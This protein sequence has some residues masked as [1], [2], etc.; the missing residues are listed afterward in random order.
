MPTLGIA[1][2]FGDNCLGRW[3]LRAVRMVLLNE[4]LRRWRSWLALALLVALVSG[5]A[6]AATTAGRRTASAF[7][8]FVQQYGFDTLT[9]AFHPTP[10]LARLPEVE[11]SSEITFA[12][13]GTPTCQ[14]AP[15]NP[16]YF[17]VAVGLPVGGPGVKLISGR[18]P[19]P[20]ST[21]EVLASFNLAQEGI[22]IGSVIHVRFDSSSQESAVFNDS[23][24]V[25]PTGPKLTFRVV[26]FEASEFE[27]PSIGTP[28]EDLYTTSAF[29][30]RYSSSLVHFYLYFTRL[31]RGALDQG[32]FQAAASK[33]DVGGFS[34]ESVAASEVASSIHPQAVGWWVL[35]ILAGAA[36]LLTIAQAF[37]RQTRVASETF[38][39]LSAVGLGS[40]ELALLNVGRALFV[41][42][43]GAA[44]GVLL[45]IVLSPLAPVGEARI[46]D[47]TGGIYFDPFVLWLGVLITVTATVLVALWPAI[48]SSRLRTAR[49]SLPG[50][51]S[52]VVAGLSAAGAP[53]TAV[54]G[55]RRVLERGQGR[56]AV[57]VGTALVAT[58]LAVLALAA[59]AVFGTSL[60]HLTSTPALYGQPFDV[61]FDGLPQQQPLVMGRLLSQLRADRGIRDITLGASQELQI[62]HQEVDAIA[63]ISVRGPVL[64]TV[65]SGRAPRAPNE[66]ALGSTT[67]RQVGAQVGG[68]VELTV[69]GISGG[70]HTERF[71]VVGTVSIPIDFGIGGLGNGAVLT[72]PGLATAQCPTGPRAAACVASAE[73]SDEQAILVTGSHR[74]IAHFERADP[75]LTSIPYPPN[76]LVNFGEAVDFPLIIGLVLLLFGAATLL[77]TLVVSATRRRSETG[78][79]KALGFVRSQLVM[80]VAWQATTIALV[81]IVIGVPLGV[82]VGNAVWHLFANNLG[83]FPDTVVL[84]SEMA[85]V[86][87]GVL[88][89][90]NLLAIAPAIISSR[91]SPAQ[92]LRAQ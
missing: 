43:G 31:K 38:P 34:D 83:L 65:V 2:A 28:S 8:R 74:A 36:G 10:Q 49:P 88:L 85:A 54:V 40:S 14:C 35:A 24:A 22:H 75:E 70:T 67:L 77:H 25:K 16:S 81:G 76:N 50:R 90:A 57:P 62:N 32:A 59:T 1:E 48:R 4:A 72:V 51:P 58:V 33:F 27:F 45:A 15:I 89:V 21:T 79:L 69:P 7:P 26:G 41:A 47:P 44:G 52:A 12:G 71:R 3:G 73:R 11:T 92:L 56:N 13:T 20:S 9:Y 66:I 23:A 6:M 18:L 29:T 46:A 78:L 39:T 53:P 80:V 19:N 37:A 82:V 42:L 63:G 5:V 60:S 64:V 91:L 86:V 55:V 68:P 61:E 84:A 87:G 17:S 30:R